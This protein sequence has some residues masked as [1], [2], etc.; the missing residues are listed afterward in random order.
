MNDL[1]T[2]KPITPSLRHRKII[3]NIPKFP[4]IDKRNLK[5]GLNKKSGRNNTGKIT[6]YRKG[7]GHKRSFRFID[8]DHQKAIYSFSQVI[9]IEYNPNST[10]NI[11]LMKILD[12]NH[13][14]YRLAPQNIQ[15][16]QIIP[17]YKLYNT[18]H[19]NNHLDL[20]HDHLPPRDS[21]SGRVRPGEVKFIKDM[22]IGTLINDVNNIARAAGTS[23]KII[24]KI[25]DSFTLVALPTGIIQE[26]SN[27]STAVVGPV[28]NPSHFNISLGKAGASR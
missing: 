7:G 17:G 12:T 15:I 19:D 9:R 24:K 3:K 28:S 8:H 2:F 25:N 4:Q 26:I 20:F 18:F 22:P 14:Y 6:S 13:Y 23:C 27:D 16:S 11:V 10:S 21:L 5:F 1:K